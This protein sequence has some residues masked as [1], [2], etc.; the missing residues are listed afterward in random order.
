MLVRQPNAHASVVTFRASINM[1]KR[2]WHRKYRDI[3]PEN[4]ED[5]G[6]VPKYM[7]EGQEG[8]EWKRMKITSARSERFSEEDQWWRIG[9]VTREGVMIKG[10]DPLQG[11][12]MGDLLAML[13]CETMLCVLTSRMELRARFETRTCSRVALDVVECDGRAFCVCRWASHGIY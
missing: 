3:S 11:S 7:L 1:S 10:V 6:G 12:W 8:A 5:A 2:V 9:M 13:N 4:A